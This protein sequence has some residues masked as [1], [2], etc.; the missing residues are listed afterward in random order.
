MTCGLVAGWFSASELVPLVI[1]MAFAAA[2]L[3]YNRQVGARA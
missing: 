2:V 1:I 3:I